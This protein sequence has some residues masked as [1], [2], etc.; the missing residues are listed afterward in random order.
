MSG[1]WTALRSLFNNRGLV[2]AK[3]AAD[4]ITSLQR[5]MVGRYGEHAADEATAALRRNPSAKWLQDIQYQY[6]DSRLDGI[7]K[8]LVRAMRPEPS[9]RG[10][11][12]AGQDDD[13][14][15]GKPAPKT[16]RSPEEIE[17][18]RQ[19][20]SQTAGSRPDRAGTKSNVQGDVAGGGTRVE[21]GKATPSAMGTAHQYQVKAPSV[22]PSVKP[23][24]KAEPGESGKNVAQQKV[25]Y[26]TLTYGLAGGERLARK[27]GVPSS[28]ERGG[29]LSPDGKGWLTKPKVMNGRALD[30]QLDVDNP[31]RPAPPAKNVSD[32]PQAKAKPVGPA[33]SGGKPL[34]RV[35]NPDTGQDEVRV[36]PGDFV[37][38]RWKPH[39]MSQKVST[40]RP[41]QA[42]GNFAHG[43]RYTN[44]KD[45]GQEVVWNG[46]DW[47]LPSVYAAG[48]A[49]KKAQA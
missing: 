29:K 18:Q 45:E 26:A 31:D 28:L 40:A 12:P 44:P 41:D 4:Y 32:L 24:I 36:R 15:D 2:E 38:Q 34:Q 1:P 17:K 20:T 39:G 9:T 13:D 48:Q 27:L 23:R 35:K 22:D 49:Q 46:E 10:G 30:K 47:V 3:T 19:A 25:D 37:G 6:M 8:D 33:G 21:P 5:Y 7:A 42:T 11:A 16:F 14:D 43:S